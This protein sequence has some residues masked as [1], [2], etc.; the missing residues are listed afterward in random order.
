MANTNGK[1]GSQKHQDVQKAEFEKTASAYEN[2]PQVKVEM[3]VPIS[4]P[5]GKKKARVADVAAFSKKKPLQFFKIVQ[6]GK[7]DKDGNPVKREQ[8][9][10]DDIESHL[11]IS[12]NFVDYEKY[13][14]D[15]HGKA[16]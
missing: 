8:E 11:D 16:D 15:Q 5:N 9:A 10:I 3:E 4:T 7:V 14:L 2:Q 13:I 1:K 12:V 6:V